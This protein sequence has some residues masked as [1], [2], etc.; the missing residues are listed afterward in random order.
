MQARCSQQ[1]NAYAYL[2]KH[3]ERQLTLQTCCVLTLTQVLT[4]PFIREVK[5]KLLEQPTL[6]YYTVLTSR[7]LKIHLS[8]DIFPFSEARSC[9]VCKTKFL[10]LINYLPFVTV[11]NVRN[12]PKRN[13]WHVFRSHRRDEG[14]FLLDEILSVDGKLPP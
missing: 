9:N 2:G 13:A 3:D 6:L 5:S 8:Y 10:L 11:P 14:N 1:N 12:V 4:K 7:R